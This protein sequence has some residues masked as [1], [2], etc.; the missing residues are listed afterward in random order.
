MGLKFCCRIWLGRRFAK[1]TFDQQDIECDVQEV[2]E[3]LDDST[4]DNSTK[5]C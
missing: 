3:L 4:N 2:R 5:P 1:I